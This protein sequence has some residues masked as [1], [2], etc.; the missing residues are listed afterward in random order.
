MNHDHELSQTT[1][2]RQRVSEASGWIQ[3]EEGREIRGEEDDVKKSRE[4]SKGTK[5]KRV[6]HHKG[7]FT[8]VHPS[9]RLSRSDMSKNTFR[10]AYGHLADCSTYKTYLEGTTYN[11]VNC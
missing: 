7:K 9:V 5:L 4:K 6:N 3:S 10:I 11:A 2:A 8:H 1:S